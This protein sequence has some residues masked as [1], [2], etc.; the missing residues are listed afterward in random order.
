MFTM[1]RSGR[2]RSTETS[3]PAAEGVPRDLAIKS[4]AL[5]AVEMTPAQIAEAQKRA[6]EW[7]PKPTPPR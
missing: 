5:V 2:S 4:R 1:G 6:R 7:K 3:I